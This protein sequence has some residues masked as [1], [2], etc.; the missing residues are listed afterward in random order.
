[1]S[2]SLILCVDIGN[3]N[4]VFGVFRDGY[5]ASQWRIATSPTKMPDE[6]GLILTGLLATEGI[7]PRD[8][9]GV[10]ICSVVPPVTSYFVS[11][12][13]RYF[14]QEPL[15]VGAEVETGLKVLY[16]DPRQVG[17][18]RIVNA[19][20]VKA[21]FGGPACVVDFG[22][23]TTFDALDADGAYLGGAICPGLRISSEALF[24]RAARL[25][26]VELRRPPSVIGRNTE[27][28][29]QSGILYG[30]V[31]LTEGL[32]Q[33][34][35]QELGEGMHVIATGGLA[36]LVA[37]ETNIFDVVDQGLTLDGLYRVYRMN[38]G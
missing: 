33:R 30:H 31:A 32:V 29:I 15:V 14:K 5:L 19:V 34:F 8:V 9:G 17:A 37:A 7:M 22:T 36:D 35:R 6:Y 38:N 13:Q 1:M 12:C 24:A 11:L 18:D 23:A 20:S 10:A 3:S 27:N 28:S 25:S 4:T 21:R 16:D 26:K 2:A